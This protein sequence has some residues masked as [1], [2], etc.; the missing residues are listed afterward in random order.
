[1][2]ESKQN[3]DYQLAE[4]GQS[5]QDNLPAGGLV[6]SETRLAGE[7]LAEVLGGNQYC[8]ATISQF[9]KWHFSSSNSSSRAEPA[10]LLDEV[11]SAFLIKKLLLSKQSEFPTLSRI[12]ERDSTLRLGLPRSLKRLKTLFNYLRLSLGKEAL[13]AQAIEQSSFGKYSDLSAEELLALFDCLER[14]YEESGLFDRIGALS[15][16]NQLP[17]AE[18]KRFSARWPKIIVNQAFP[19]S[20]LEDSLYSKYFSEQLSLEG[21]ELSAFRP[22]SE[23]LGIPKS[24]GRISLEPVEPESWRVFKSSSL[25]Q[26][27][28]STT[29][30]VRLRQ[31]ASI[32]DEV[33]WT[34]KAIK[35]IEASGRQAQIFIPNLEVY[36]DVLAKEAKL[37]G[38]EICIPKGTPFFSTE[39]GRSLRRLEKAF[40]EPGLENLASFYS[41]AFFSVPS[42]EQTLGELSG[43]AR[44][45]HKA[46]IETCLSQFEP[47]RAELLSSLLQ[48]LSG[49][50]ID[51]DAF[52]K[53][54]H[55]NYSKLLSVLEQ[56]SLYRGSTESIWTMLARFE[57]YLTKASSVS[58]EKSKEILEFLSLAISFL[59]EIKVIK[60]SAL[61]VST[62]SEVILKNFINNRLSE[63]REVKGLT[64]SLLRLE[65]SAWRKSYQALRRLRLPASMVDNSSGNG[66]SPSWC[67]KM[68]LAG[69]GEVNLLPE[70][71]V[72]VVCSELLDIRGL[73]GQDSYLL[74][75]T[76]EDFEVS[77][78]PVLGTELD[79]FCEEIKRERLDYAKEN[80][81][82][83]AQ[84]FHSSRQVNISWPTNLA[85]ASRSPASFVSQLSLYMPYE[86][87]SLSSHSLRD[88][89]EP[90]SFGSGVFSSG[91]ARV[92]AIKARK[93]PEFCAYEGN[94]T[95]SKALHEKLESQGLLKGS[96]SF[97]SASKLELLADCP[98][99]FFFREV[100]NLNPREH[101]LKLSFG[102]EI[103]SL[104]HR[105]L[106]SYF[107][108]KPQSLSFEEQCKLVGE[109]AEVEFSKSLFDWDSS[110]LTRVE[111]K[112]ILGGL[113]QSEGSGKRGVLKGFLVFQEKLIK[114]QPKFLELAFGR[115]G[116]PYP[117]LELKAESGSVSLSG[118]VDRV[119]V[120]EAGNWFVWDYKTGKVDGCSAVLKGKNLQLPLYALF[121]SQSVFE[122]SFP[123]RAGFVVLKKPNRQDEGI[124]NIN[125]GILVEQLA[126]KRGRGFVLDAGVVS[127]R[128][129]EV[130]ERVFGLNKL[131]RQGDFSQIEETEACAICEFKKICSR[132]ETKLASKNQ[133]PKL[134]ETPLAIVS[135]ESDFEK[136]LP[137]ALGEIR[138]SEKQRAAIDP[139]KSVVLRAGAGVGKTHVLMGR[140]L[141]LLL[142][143]VRAEEIVAITFTEKAAKEISQR[144]KLAINQTLAL[145]A[146]DGVELSPIE[147]ERL[148]A[149]RDELSRAAIGTI[150]SFCTQ[151]IRLGG[152]GYLS[153]VIDE[154]RWGEFFERSFQELIESTA[155]EDKLETLFSSGFD[156]KSLRSVLMSLVSDPFSL[157]KLSGA[158]SI[159]EEGL[160]DYLSL[161]GEFYVK[162]ASSLSYELSSFLESWLD[163]ASVWRE[164]YSFKTEEIK[165]LWVKAEALVISLLESLKTC[166]PGKNSKPYRALEV[167]FQENS[168]Q[169]AVRVKKDNPRNFWKEMKDELSKT[170]YQI[171]IQSLEREKVNF[172]LCQDLLSLA[173][174]LL[175]SF[176]KRKAEEDLFDYEDLLSRAWELVV[177]GRN[178]KP[179]GL[180][181]F[182]DL[183]KHFLV[184]EFQDTDR[185][186][187]EIISKLF[188]IA[189]NSNQLEK[190]PLPSIFVVGD[191][192][193]GIYGFR[194]AEGDL[195]SDAMELLD[196]KEELRLD[197]SWR[198]TSSIIEFNNSLFST[199]FSWDWREDG[200]PSFPGAVKALPLIPAKLGKKDSS[201]VETVLLEKNPS[202]SVEAEVIAD[203]LES[204]LT[205]IREG[206]GEWPELEERVSQQRSE[207]GV[208]SVLCRTGA[209]VSRLADCFKLKGLPFE[210]ARNKSFFELPEILA[211]LNF[212][213]ALSCETN[214]IAESGFFR[215]FFGGLSDEDLLD[216]EQIEQGRSFL[217]ACRVKS[218]T[219]GV[220]SLLDTLIQDLDLE[221]VF[222]EAGALKDFINVQNFIEFVISSERAGEHD[223]T[224]QSFLLWLN[225]NKN[226]SRF[227]LGVS[228]G[229]EAI[230]LSTIHAAKGLEYP[231]VVLPFL[232]EKKRPEDDMVRGEFKGRALIS[233][234][235]EDPEGDYARK[236]TL[237]S[238]LLERQSQLKL[239]SEERRVFY[240]AC[241][242][243][244]DKLILF[245]R[246]GK[247]LQGRAVMATNLSPSDWLAA[248]II[249][250]EGVRPQ[251]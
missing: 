102:R 81:F 37:C 92:K 162:E 85:G 192:Q 243:A 48:L 13:I 174:L 196:I 118:I 183:Y 1:M 101:W 67:L 112:Q 41:S 8:F 50:L 18:L 34:L 99:R 164:T 51:G 234:K 161:V 247:K 208:I 53:C 97:F 96:S 56:A 176:E 135:S 88:S 207:A 129:D 249:G 235:L 219:L 49:S 190:T 227:S 47:E 237:L 64:P 106:Y 119:D 246:E 25:C 3:S 122:G 191:S 155:A 14:V 223:G 72:G 158:G 185:R 77:S 160:D 214:Q 43:E 111:K 24:K 6:L 35:S 212:I 153:S 7:V 109:L 38:V 163:E 204:I 84:L 98:H 115:K 145:G 170:K 130:Q 40:T 54:R 132:N 165:P 120:D 156:L 69:L 200:Q 182:G 45:I 93:S 171:L 82:L 29:E 108:K 149:G 240:V 189:E 75:L 188:N 216:T 177:Q 236:K 79:S 46:D 58:S 80:S 126:F 21:A 195:F 127:E 173:D 210:V 193:Q 250:S 11:E 71:K 110:V 87:Y 121:L 83:L 181:L 159:Y 152:E 179:H 65:L 144:V 245:Q 55:K 128:L 215:S 4:L 217:E 203:K 17:P 91:A 186:Q 194:G 73:R 90:A 241:T 113:D 12:V 222:S 2:P 100:L 20:E 148:I 68:L 78:E 107:K 57:R 239:A 42:I 70:K 157:K 86:N 26:N 9:F 60:Q 168:T 131:L 32:R 141:R 232:K 39:V 248:S 116:D 10:K 61:A 221:R 136:K 202:L 134:L 242:R 94:I 167:F 5:I 231:L 19:T 199:L 230:V 169:A 213:E 206:R 137:K 23:S 103:G 187:W 140:V 63:P 138:F 31:F 36:R 218:G 104:V 44:R 95:N 209:E 166:E 33:H 74:G 52:L 244:A 27:P 251:N 147:R 225:A 228:Q 229:S 150:H 125:S 139:F 123:T 117:A 220:G 154:V 89:L 22:F 142:A 197:E 143:G 66:A 105:V 238:R 201:D 198:S 15:F 184:D 151:I 146:F 205:S 114:T 178:L 172:S 233:L 211:C 133:E 226:S 28:D 175:G 62:S 16:L 224:P 59:L 180:S 30:H 76:E 124:Y